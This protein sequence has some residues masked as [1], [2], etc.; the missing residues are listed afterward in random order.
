M[1]HVKKS[2]EALGIVRAIAMDIV[3]FLEFRSII[4]PG[5]GRP[6]Q[7]IHKNAEEKAKRFS[8]I[9]QVK[10]TLM[11][12]V[13]DWLITGDSYTWKGEDLDKDI[14]EIVRNKI[15]EFGVEVEDIDYKQFLDEDPEEMKQLVYVPST[16][17]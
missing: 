1:F 4:K 17:V 6:S 15:K 10:Q 16:T 3:T 9:H 7:D 2:P 8:K 14:T 5:K 13:M 11:S 12:N